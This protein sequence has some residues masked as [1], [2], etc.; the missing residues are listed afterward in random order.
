MIRCCVRNCDT[1]ENV[2][3]CTTV[4][5]VSFPTDPYLREEWI[6]VLS[7][8]DSLPFD[9]LDSARICSCHFAEEAFGKHPVHGYRFLLPRA[10]P[11]VFPNTNKIAIQDISDTE[12]EPEPDPVIEQFIEPDEGAD[13]VFFYDENSI[14][15]V[16]SLKSDELE[17]IV[18]KEPTKTIGI[19]YVDGK[20]YF[21]QSEGESD[22]DADVDDLIEQ[23]S[24]I[25]S[26]V[27]SV[28]KEQL[29]LPEDDQFES[30][31]MELN[32][33]TSKKKTNADESLTDLDSLITTS[34]GPEFED[35]L[36][37]SDHMIKPEPGEEIDMVDFSQCDLL[38]VK[39]SRS[40]ITDFGT[41]EMLEE[42]K[43]SSSKD[44]NKHVCEYCK[45][46][47]A[48][49]SG[50][51]KHSLVHT[52]QKPHACP[53]CGR[54]F[55]QKVNLTIHMKQ[56]TGEESSKKF[57]CP[58][59]QKGCTRM[60]ELKIHL[61]THW[62][63]TPHGCPLCTERFGEI[64]NF[65]EHIKTRHKDDLT[66]QEAIQMIA[67]DENTE[68]IACGTDE[69]QP[70]IDGEWRCQV[71]L[72]S[73]RT[74]RLLSKHKRKM[75]PK[76]F[77]CTFCPKQFLYRSLLDKHTT[78]HTQE[79]RFLCKFCD[80]RFSQKINLDV[81]LLKIHNVGDR[82][83]VQKQYECSYCPK[84]FDRQSSLQLHV[85]VHTKERPFGCRDCPKAFASN[86][87]LAAH[88]R[89][90][91]LGESILLQ[92]RVK[93]SEPLASVGESESIILEE[94][95]ETEGSQTDQIMSE[96]GNE[97]VSYSIQFFKN[98]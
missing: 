82:K 80:A 44:N 98:S 3:N 14:D 94:Q 76:V 74:E 27:S 86:S 32:L 24:V 96:Q 58:I 61:K 78:V 5:F 83:L 39:D 35:K 67:Q 13:D 2:V 88:I 56:H 38:T 84:L 69:E 11:S 62:K 34:D 33:M 63:K 25:A 10:I 6:L 53:D 51:K 36:D 93:K 92:S 50:L 21:L 30:S 7:S 68:V 17:D 28:V 40:V 71:C 4:F 15:S 29:K 79:K 89:T 64:T 49:L 66:L 57:F 70:E 77:V 91:H 65:Y 54:C 81:H 22:D 43:P 72:K 16:D 45:K 19:Q 47:F 59:C 52:G 95:I 18:P 46:G 48:Y 9:D 41:I 75:H 26:E 85:R 20:Y 8:H 31:S 37:I 97:I 87:A 73:F 55:S 12:L 60:S 90:S 42:I 23:D 1:D